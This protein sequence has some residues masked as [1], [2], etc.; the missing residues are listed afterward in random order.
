MRLNL[1]SLYLEIG[2]NTIVYLHNSQ[3][4]EYCYNEHEKSET[5][6]VEYIQEKQQ[7]RVSTGTT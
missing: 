7:G 5:A 6:L 3:T 4:W 2:R 1:H